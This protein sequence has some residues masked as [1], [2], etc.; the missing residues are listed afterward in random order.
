MTRAFAVLS[1][2]G[3]PLCAVPPTPATRCMAT[4]LATIQAKDKELARLSMR[5]REA[6][7]VL[8]GVCGLARRA[9]ELFGRRYKAM[10]EQ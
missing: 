10:D 4:G 6:E 2:L 8:E 1:G 7:A 9:G 5:I 3:I